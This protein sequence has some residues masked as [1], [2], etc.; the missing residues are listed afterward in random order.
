M[1]VEQQMALAV[2]QLEIINGSTL[3]R[4]IFSNHIFTLEI[5]R[6]YSEGD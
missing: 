5:F 4:R 3:G 1:T 2:L 6:Q